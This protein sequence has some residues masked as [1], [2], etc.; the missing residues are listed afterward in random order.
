MSGSFGLGLMGSIVLKKT[1]EE[2][3]TRIPEEKT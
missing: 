2:L 1:Q 3:A